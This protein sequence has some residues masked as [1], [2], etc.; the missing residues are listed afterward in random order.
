MQDKDILEMVIPA[1]RA[2]GMKVF[3]EL[4]EP[5]FKYEGHGSVNTV[6][7]PNLPQLLEV[8]V[9]GRIGS[10][11]STSNPDYRNWIHSM[12]ED[13]CRNYDIDG[14]MWCNERRSPLDQMMLGQA[15]TDFSQASRN[16]AIQR[17]IDV[18]RVRLAHQDVYQYF[19]KA[20]SGEQ[21][22]DGSFIEFLRV[23]LANPEILIWEKFWLERNKD[24]DRELYGIV[25]WCNADLSFG[26]NVWNRNHFN[27]LRKAQYPWEEQTLYADWVK[28]ITYQHQAGQIY[29]SEMTVFHQSILRDFTPEE[30]TPLMYKLLGL[31]EASWSDIIQT[32]MDPDTYIFGQCQDAVRGV[33]GKASV[34]MGIGVD[35]PRLRKDQAVCTPD[36]VRR[37]VLASYRAGANG[38]VFAPNY[39]SMK[40]SNLAGAAE[41]LKELGL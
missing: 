31:N 14:V 24:L 21:F 2:R 16:E 37:S 29:V 27:P 13:Q 23:L 4:M 8:D 19:Q 28:P 36:I 25:K 40:L 41:A 10:D 18:E 39:A 1:A 15:P 35:A 5:F 6:N 38:V 22:A 32:G 17:G 7:I 34:Y 33:K 9:F 3:I 26:L 11:P 12:V 20:L 30:L